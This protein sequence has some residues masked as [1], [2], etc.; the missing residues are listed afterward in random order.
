MWQSWALCKRVQKWWLFSSTQQRKKSWL[1]QQ[2]GTN[3]SQQRDV[4]PNAWIAKT[5]MVHNNKRSMCTEIQW[6]LNSGCTDHIIKDDRFFNKCIILKK[7]IN[8]YLGDN[9]FLKTTKIGNVLSTFN[10]Y[11]I[12]N[13]VKM[14]NVFYAK[15][16]TMNFIS[17]SNL[18][19]KN[20]MIILKRNSAK[21]NCYCIERE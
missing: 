19:G 11:G 4:R 18:T 1:Q 6:L 3:I 14:N 2:L 12:N 15:D 10:V 9:T 13:K 17:V 16:M 21:I 7:P 8:I 20:N 5:H